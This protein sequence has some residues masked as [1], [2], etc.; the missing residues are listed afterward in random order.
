MTDLLA[1]RS[2]MAMSLAFH[3]IFACIGIGMPLLMVISESLWLKTQNKVYLSLAKKWAKGTAI[4]FA[5]GAVSGTVLSFE[6]GL[7]WP[8][9]MLHAGPIIGMP[10]SLEGFAFFLEAIFLGIYL[11]GWDRVSSKM[12]LFSGIMVMLSGMFSGIFV[13]M[14]NAWMN[15]PAGFEW[16]N[17]QFVNIDPFTAML[18]PSALPYALHMTLAAFV[19]VA[20]V[21]AGIHAFVLLRKPKS[22]FHYCALRIALSVAIVTS[23]LQP[24]SGDISA[25]NTAKQQP[26]KL[27][28]ME[29]QWET[30]KGAPLRIGGWPD[31][32]NEQTLYAIEIPYLLSFLSFG[33][34][35][36][37]V[38]G[39]KEFPKE[40]RPPVAVVHFAFQIMVG[41]G[42][43]MMLLGMIG[44]YFFLRKQPIN[45]KV[46]YL[47]LLVFA[48]PMGFIATEAGWT[49][50]EV[51]RQPW[52]IYNIMRTSDAVTT[53]P[54]LVVPFIVFTI[55]Y[56]FL[57]VMVLYLMRLYVLNSYED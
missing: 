56:I 49:V 47:R 9:F 5:V 17:G 32:E 50:T 30:E 29:A 54:N 57:F 33:T 15:S 26:A 14:A 18:N 42:S 40:D 53:M 31:V 28:A 45:N 21:V 11:Y 4:M 25:K 41:C 52:I 37:E 34:F 44:A 48:A 39:L 1:A 43:F 2:Q 13:V 55:L 10:F 46:W 27:A 20:F 51:G 7:L 16:V 6:L 35:D 3:I 12:H 38:K 36:A 22:E 23:I 8:E 19:S 24:I